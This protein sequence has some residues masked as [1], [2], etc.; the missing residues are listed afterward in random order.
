MVLILLHYQLE[1]LY[2]YNEPLYIKEGER[3]S[4][5]MPRALVASY[6]YLSGSFT[7]AFATDQSRQ[8]HES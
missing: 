1:K 8:Q 7:A 2:I 3:E 6:I 5:G 4:A